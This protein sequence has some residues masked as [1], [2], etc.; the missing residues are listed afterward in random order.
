MK[1]VQVLFVLGGLSQ[2]GGV[3]VGFLTASLEVAPNATPRVIN[4]S[5]EKKEQ[6]RGDR[7][8]RWDIAQRFTSPMLFSGPEKPQKKSTNPAR[9]TYGKPTGKPGAEKA[10]GTLSERGLRVT[11]RRHLGLRQRTQSLLW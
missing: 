1:V 9:L 5:Q 2:E 7:N 3:R 11:E 6:S 4:N 8:E 10:G